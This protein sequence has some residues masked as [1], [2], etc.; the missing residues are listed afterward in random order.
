MPPDRTTNLS[1]LSWLQNG[2]GS[3]QNAWG[4]ADCVHD[5]VTRLLLCPR[6]DSR[7]LSGP[8]LPLTQ[9][10]SRILRCS[11]QGRSPETVSP[12]QVSSGVWSEVTWFPVGLPCHQPIPWLLRLPCED[13]PRGLL[14]ITRAPLDWLSPLHL[15]R[16]FHRILPGVHEHAVLSHI[17]N[18]HPVFKSLSFSNS[19]SISFITFGAKSV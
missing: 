3:R 19:H 18:R 11:G 17:L 13:G 16:A 1:I 6:Q 10:T 14:F 8:K 7:R 9:G 2:C 5:H 12:P 4:S 15:A